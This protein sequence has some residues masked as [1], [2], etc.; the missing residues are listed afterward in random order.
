M[1]QSGSQYAY[2][3]EASN[4]LYETNSERK[5][6]ER[7]Y[8]R[9]Q[10]EKKPKTKKKKKSC[11]KQMTRFSKLQISYN[12]AINRVNV[13]STANYFLIRIYISLLFAKCSSNFTITHENVI[14]MRHSDR[15]CSTAIR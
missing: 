10:I 8:E 5:K 15:R 3:D 7:K 14:D 1:G 12:I 4:K 6:R 2:D 11:T 9:P 13:A